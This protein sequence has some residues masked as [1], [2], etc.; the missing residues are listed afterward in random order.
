MFA[1]GAFRIA[2]F[3]RL[4]AAARKGAPG[5]EGQLVDRTGHEVMANVKRRDAAVASPARYVFHRYALA[6]ADRAVGNAL[7]PL[8]LRIPEEPMRERTLQRYLKRVEV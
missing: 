2:W 4:K 5:A 6:R 7:R 8:V 1:G 3:S